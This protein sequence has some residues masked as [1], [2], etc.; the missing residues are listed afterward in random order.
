[1]SQG[2][3]FQIV[4]AA[5]AALRELKHVRAQSFV[6]ARLRHRRISRQEAAAATQKTEEPPTAMERVRWKNIAHTGM[7]CL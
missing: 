6:T 5:I 4:G 2:R 3:V 7:Q 1:M